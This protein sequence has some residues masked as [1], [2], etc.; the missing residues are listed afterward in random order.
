MKLAIFGRVTESTDYKVLLRYFEYLWYADI[1]YKVYRQY[2]LEICERKPEMFAHLPIAQFT[3]PD[4]L[5]DTTFLMSFGGDGTVLECV[6][7]LGNHATQLPILGVNFGRLGYLTS[8]TQHDIISATDALVK[9]I[10][11]IEERGLLSVVS[12]PPGLFGDKNFGLNDL[13]IHKTNTNEMI[14]IHVY[15]NGE[16]LNSYRGDGLVI[17]TPT[18]ST[19]YSLACGGPIIFPTSQNFIITP[20]AP[21]SLTVRPVVVPDSWVIS[22]EVESRSGTAM[23]ALDTRTEHIKAGTSLAIRKANFVARI[24]RMPDTKYIATLRRT[25]MWGLDSRK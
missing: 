22:C 13:T 17:A 5:I 18:G 14:S 6:R 3:N 20:V 2:W 8:I 21:H 7:M 12:D 19:A 10:Y 23:V 24:V 1:P 4:D 16:F 25:L 9:G 11:R 15:V